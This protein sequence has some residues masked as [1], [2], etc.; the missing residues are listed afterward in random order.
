MSLSALGFS[1][2]S[3]RKPLVEC[4]VEIMIIPHF[5]HWRM[6]SFSCVRGFSHGIFTRL[7][8]LT[9]HPGI[10]D[11]HCFYFAAICCHSHCS[12][13]YSLFPT[14]LLSLSPLHLP[15]EGRCQNVGRPEMTPEMT[16]ETL[17]GA[18]SL[19]EPAQQPSIYRERCVSDVVLVSNS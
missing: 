4:A 8:V 15:Y 7:R 6:H 16:P 3:E 13:L 11:F 9:R 12:K 17:S 19:N 1:A 14:F 2:R 10:L 18:Q 5:F